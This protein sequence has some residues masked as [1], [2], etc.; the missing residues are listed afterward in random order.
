MALTSTSLDSDLRLRFE[1]GPEGV[2]RLTHRQAGGLCHIGKPYWDGKVLLT[3]LINPTAGFFAGDRL[4]AEIELGAGASVLLS[5]P[6]ATRLHT[7][8]HGA[9]ELRQTFRLS[10]HSWLEVL[11][12]LLIP[13]KASEATLH[14]RIELHPSAS[15]VYL[16]LLA[17]GRRAHGE[18]L[19]FRRLATALDLVTHEG[20]PLARERARLDPT[21]DAWRLQT[22]S[23][24]PAFVGTFWLHLPGWS[25]FSSLFPHLETLPGKLQVG[26][27][28]LSPDLF[29]IRLLTPDSLAL[30]RACLIVRESLA[31]HFPRLLTRTGKL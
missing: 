27:S 25:A 2:T 9:S 1:A 5:S 7:M 24:E 14:T 26:A 3:Q 20:I 23:G 18:A 19:A 29:V 8:H 28:Q 15:L 4:V 11:P 10:E 13:Q 17:P 30:R 22:A 6:S 31:C 21:T 12:D 16:D